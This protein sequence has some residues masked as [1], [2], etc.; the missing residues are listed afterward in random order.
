MFCLNLQLSIFIGNHIKNENTGNKN[1][2]CGPQ[3]GRFGFGNITKITPGWNTFTWEEA[4]THK[5]APVRLAILDAN[6][7]ARV[8]LLDHIPHDDTTSP[9]YYVESSF[10]PYHMSVF[11]PDIQCT[12]CT[13]QMINFMTDKTVNCN[14]PTCYYNPQDSACKGSTDPNAKTCTGAPNNDVCALENECFSNCK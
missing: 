2:P 12:N 14:I 10:V 6:E 3:S 7:T 4:I 11:I 9:N 5:G 8:I 1:G 13:I